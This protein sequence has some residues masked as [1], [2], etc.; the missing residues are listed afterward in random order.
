[1]AYR[2]AKELL[3]AFRAK[4]SASRLASLLEGSG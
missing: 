3:T 1:M 4:G 2:E